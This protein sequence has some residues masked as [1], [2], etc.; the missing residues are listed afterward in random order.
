MERIPVYRESP[1][2]QPSPPAMSVASLLI[3]IVVANRG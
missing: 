2:A 1:S 3:H